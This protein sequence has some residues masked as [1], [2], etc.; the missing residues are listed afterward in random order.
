MSRNLD[1]TLA[2]SLSA[3][4]I[5][6]VLFV[7]ITFNSGV[8]YVWSG[9]G[10]FDF[11]GHTFKGVGNLGSIGP[12]GEG[13]AVKADGTTVTLSGIGYSDI[14][15]PAP[16]VTP[17]APPFTPAAGESVAWSFATTGAI[18]SSSFS[19]PPRIF[20]SFLGCSG[21]GSN[22]L[23]SGTLTILNGDSFCPTIHIE[24]GG[25]AIPP[26]I[27][28]GAT[29]TRAYPVVRWSSNPGGFQQVVAS[30]GGSITGSVGLNIAP[31]IN[32]VI[33]AQMQNTLTGMSSIAMFID[34]VGVA[35]YYTGTPLTKTSLIYEALQDVRMGAPAKIWYGL[36]ANGSLL[37]TPYLVFSGTVDKP[38]AQVDEKSASITLA[39]ENRLV[40]LQRANQRRYTAADQKLAYPTDLGFHWV[41]TLED[42]ALRWG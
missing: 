21:A 20:N 29:I 18:H 32:P 4:V 17:P 8:E 26:E 38:T 16:P 14:N 6:P 33:E 36:M 12:I 42:I 5:Q 31:D 15:V 41:E 1:P 24:W 7:Q 34:F 30:P 19:I 25:F 2:A 11:N 27:P 9:I 35:V 37:G 28:R 39:L 3:G 22:T 23:Y 13:S 40:N 10:D